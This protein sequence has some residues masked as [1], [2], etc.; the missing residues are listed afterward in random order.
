MPLARSVDQMAVVPGAR[1]LTS[2]KNVLG[3]ALGYGVWE[4]RRWRRSSS[5]TGVHCTNE[6]VTRASRWNT[7]ARKPRARS[8]AGESYE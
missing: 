5:G 1:A 4:V 8:Y 3:C 6:F 2:T 7:P